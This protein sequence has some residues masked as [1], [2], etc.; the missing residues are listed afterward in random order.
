MIESGLGIWALSYRCST[1][2]GR[3]VP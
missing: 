2:L 1:Y 3:Q